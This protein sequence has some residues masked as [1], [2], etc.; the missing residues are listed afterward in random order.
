MDVRGDPPAISGA[1]RTL[2]A[3][4]LLSAKAPQVKNQGAGALP[5]SDGP[6]GHPRKMSRWLP[7][8]PPPETADRGTNQRWLPRANA[9][10]FLLYLWK[11]ATKTR[12]PL[13]VLI[14]VD[15]ETWPYSP[16][17]REEG[18]ECDLR[19]DIYGITEDGQFGLGFQCG[20]LRDH[21]LK[22]VFFVEA[23]FASVVG[24]NPLRQV[25]QTIWNH[26]GQAVELHAHP[27]WVKYFADD[28][29]IPR[30]SNLQH[31]HQLPFEQQVS[32]LELASSNLRSAGVG[33]IHGFRAGNFGAD[34]ATCRALAA[35]G[36]PFDFSY[37]AAFLNRDCRFDLTE[38]LFA[39]TF[40][41]GVTE[42]P[43]SYFEDY[44]NHIRPAQLCACSSQEMQLALIR[45]WQ[46]GWSCFVILSH[47]FELIKDRKCLHGKTRLNPTALR[48]MEKLCKFLKDN[49]DRFETTTCEALSAVSEPTAQAGT[50]LR[51]SLLNTLA[52]YCEQ[53][54]VRLT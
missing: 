46:S 37:N 34:L 2:L 6:P 10:V 22:A 1:E 21:G 19:R 47:S 35:L 9:S 20:L 33:Q 43:M 44:P 49:N 31:F 40:L 50:P 13:T 42:Y 5:P 52:R 29:G 12:I 41:G 4:W 15:T 30:P 48:R 11:V 32:L 24:I 28:A 25:V 26:D 8:L 54:W 7:A 45:A 27:E 39:P 53:A 23:L 38:R 16:G 36:V 3:G 17:W 51:G 14:T 18:L